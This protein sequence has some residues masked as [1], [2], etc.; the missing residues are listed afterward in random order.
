MLRFHYNNDPNVRDCVGFVYGG[1]RGNANNFKS[2]EECTSQCR[3][4]IRLKT[5]VKTKDVKASKRI[6]GCTGKFGCCDDYVT[7]AKGPNQEGCPG[8]LR[9]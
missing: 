7:P 2:A 4:K 6:P 3:D 5:I 8:T 1:C 9:T